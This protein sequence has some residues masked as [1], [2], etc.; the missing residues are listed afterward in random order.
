LGALFL[1]GFGV[2]GLAEAHEIGKI[3]SAALVNRDDVM[4]FIGGNVKPLVKALFAERV[5]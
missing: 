3:M 5:L 4:S 1:T 2:A